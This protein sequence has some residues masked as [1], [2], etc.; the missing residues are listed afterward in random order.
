MKPEYWKDPETR[1]RGT[2]STAYHIRY[3]ARQIRDGQRM[4]AGVLAEIVKSANAFRLRD[5]DGNVLPLEENGWWPV[6]RPFYEIAVRWETAQKRGELSPEL[7]DELQVEMYEAA[8]E[9][10]GPRGGPD[11]ERETLRKV[12]VVQEYEGGRRLSEPKSVVRF[13]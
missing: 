12:T 6:Y 1:A 4:P 3:L 10:L 9:L 13:W 5:E 8:L 7:A 2:R 11:G